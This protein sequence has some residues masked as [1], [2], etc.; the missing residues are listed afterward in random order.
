MATKIERSRLREA[1]VEMADDM[2]RLG[3]IDDAKH[4]KIAMGLS[5]R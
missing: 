5:V 1:I 4:R 3:I 2:H